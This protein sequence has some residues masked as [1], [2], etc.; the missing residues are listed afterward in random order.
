MLSCSW[1]RSAYC[2][3]TLCIRSSIEP[4]AIRYRRIIA[5]IYCSSCLSKPPTVE[6]TLSKR[7]TAGRRFSYRH[8]SASSPPRSSLAEVLVDVFVRSAQSRAS[9]SGCSS[10]DYR[11]DQQ[12]RTESDQSQRGNQNQRQHSGRCQRFMRGALFLGEHAFA[13][14]LCRRQSLLAHL[15]RPDRL[16]HHRRPPSLLI[17]RPHRLAADT[18]LVH[19]LSFLTKG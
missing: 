12:H 3:S 19:V 18:R 15:R 6:L 16:L 5:Y 8:A 14:E 17:A 9:C 10:S 13:G 7:I 2:V 4:A 1:S 11:Q